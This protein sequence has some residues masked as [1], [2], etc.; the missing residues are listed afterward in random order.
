MKTKDA[1]R[2]DMS[3]MLVPDT[4][5]FLFQRSHGGWDWCS[6]MS[7][8]GVACEEAL[9]SASGSASIK[10]GKGKPIAGLAGQIITVHSVERTQA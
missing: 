9:S 8:T 6:A 1:A 2:K 4:D 10:D 3:K 7:L 5:A